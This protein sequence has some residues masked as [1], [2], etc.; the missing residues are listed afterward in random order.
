MCL[1][2]LILLGPLGLGSRCSLLISGNVGMAGVERLLLPPL[3]KTFIMVMFELSEQLYL[4]PIMI[5]TAS[6]TINLIQIFLRLKEVTDALQLATKD[7]DVATSTVPLDGLQH[8]SVP[9]Q[10]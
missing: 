10:G 1:K 4:T 8:V 6:Q 2:I 3:E 7:L 5:I 9:I